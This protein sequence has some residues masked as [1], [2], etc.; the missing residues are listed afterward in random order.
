MIMKSPNPRQREVVEDLQNNIVLFASAGTGKTFTVANRVANILAKGKASGEEILCLTFTI[1]ASNELKEDILHYAGDLAQEVTVATIHGFCYRLLLEEHKRTGERGEYFGIC[2]EIDEEEILRDILSQNFYRWRMEKRLAEEKI[3]IPDLE[4]CPVRRMENSN[5][6]YWQIDEYLIDCHGNVIAIDE[7]QVLLPLETECPDC[8]KIVP[9]QGRIC[10]S[11]QREFSFTFSEKK[12]E[13]YARKTSVRAVISELKHVREELELYTED[14]VADYQNAFA[15]VKREKSKLYEGLVSYFAKYVG[16]TPDEDF[17]GAMSEFAGRLASEYDAR[18][19]ASNCMDFD[20]LII[21]ANRLLRREDSLAFWSKKYKY[22]TLDE[23]Q[24]TSR[25]EY[26]LLKKLFAKNNVLLCGDFFQTIYGWRGSDPEEILG[27]YVKRFSAKS[28]MLSENYRST[29]TLSAA[30][31]GYLK[32]TYPKLIGKYCPQDFSIHCEE[33][34]EPIYCYAFANR[35]EEAAQIYKYLQRSRLRPADV[36][37]I[38]RSNKYIAELS[39]LLAKEGGEKENSLRFF[40]VEEGIQ[41]F[42][43]PVVKDMLAVLKL[44]VNP[45]DTM[46]LERLTEKFVKRVGRKTIELLRSYGEL[47]ISILSFID[48]QS[49]LLGD[50]YQRLLEGYERNAIVVYDTE[51]TGLDLEKDEMVQLSAIKMGKDGIA[52]RLDIL[53]EPTL[54]IGKEAEETHGFSLEYIRAHGGVTAKDALELFASFVEGCVLVGHNNLAYDK[55]LVA[56]QLSDNELPPL[57]TEAEYDTLL[58]AKA[59][60][61]FLEN[62]KLSTLC[63]HFSVVNACAHNALGDITATGECLTHIIREKLLPTTMERQNIIAKHV[64]K[65]KGLYEFLHEVNRRVDVGEYFGAY[66]A[67]SLFLSKRYPNFADRMAVLD[68][69]EGLDSAHG[70]GRAFLKEYLRD[71]SL[72]GSQMDVL[73]QKQNKIPIITVHQAKGCEFD[74]VI[75]AGADDSNF[76]S[77]GARQ[78]GNEE[79]EKKIFYVAITRAKRKLILTRALHEG[80]YD[81]RESP[82][83]WN[84][85]E[86]Y[87]HANRA[88]KNSD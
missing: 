14:D 32:N 30:T 87:V 79:E 75:V 78:S 82:Y 73:L 52:D 5:A 3:P 26:S 47:G 31:F 35:E 59:F 7:E 85:P 21:G 17:E 83:V 16:S 51:T 8:G 2:D 25:L 64:D 42:K 49:Q 45:L 88:W 70:N 55:P 1:K 9:L 71:A 19:K 61:P 29:K 41:L 38:A 69:V 34:G 15:Y 43:K 12:F 60:Y 62:F 74:T 40:T 80:R 67:E 44:V 18:L 37:V 20:D 27:D 28:Y 46:S 81:R 72:S 76:P 11:C 57:L 22:I 4:N 58:L 36:C 68:V 6:I 39:R 33:S 10:P 84:I 24:D 86:E 53:I 23:M 50:P 65:F 13:V 63:E 56:R 77:Y 48:S 66:V 54:P